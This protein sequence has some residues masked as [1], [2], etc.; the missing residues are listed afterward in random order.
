MPVNSETLAWASRPGFEKTP[1]TQAKQQE[2]LTQKRGG[3]GYRCDKAAFEAR[4]PSTHRSTAGQG[5]RE[6]PPTEPTLWDGE[7]E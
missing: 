7:A 3:G 6:W 1:N 2:G 5:L 4:L